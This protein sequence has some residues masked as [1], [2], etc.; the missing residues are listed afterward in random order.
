MDVWINGEPRSIAQGTS[1][2]DLLGELGYKDFFVA[3]AI[4]GICIARKS[5]PETPVVPGDKLEILA[6]MAGG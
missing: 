5:Y 6:P 3:I 4:N 2:S 1:V